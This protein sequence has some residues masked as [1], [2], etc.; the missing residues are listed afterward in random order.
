MAF[1]WGK[2]GGGVGET[3]LNR[4]GSRAKPK[5]HHLM[6]IG[7]TAKLRA[8]SHSIFIKFNITG[9]FF[10]FLFIYFFKMAS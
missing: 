4:E 1:F 6:L 7:I 9:A 3:G 2:G 10:N 5:L 8:K